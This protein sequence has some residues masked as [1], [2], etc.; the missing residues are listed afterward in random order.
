MLEKFK[1]SRNMTKFVK[2]RN[3]IAHEYFNIKLSAVWLVIKND[4]AN[5]KTTVQTILLNE[6]E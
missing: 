4:L 1:L 5:L 3:M 2:F 6:F